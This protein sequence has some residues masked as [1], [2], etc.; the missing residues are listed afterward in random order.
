VGIAMCSTANALREMLQWVMNC[1]AYNKQA[2]QKDFQ[3]Q[4]RRQSVGAIVSGNLYHFELQ[5]R[6]S[7]FAQSAEII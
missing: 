5:K 2:R 1:L 6:A 3:Y 7:C 4:T